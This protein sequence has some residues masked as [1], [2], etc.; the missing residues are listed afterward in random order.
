M[1]NWLSQRHRSPPLQ[2]SEKI[3]RLKE[4]GTANEQSSDEIIY[5]IEVPANRFVLLV[6]Y[7][8]SGTIC[9]VW[10]GSAEPCGS[11]LGRKES[12]DIIL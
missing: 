1:V 4:T 10:R 3:M 7:S 12:L 9:C 2:T 11:S 5:K 8:E 6:R